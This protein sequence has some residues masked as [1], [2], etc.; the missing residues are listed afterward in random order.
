MTM[1]NRNHQRYIMPDVS[2]KSASVP[3]RN[4][5]FNK[6]LLNSSLAIIMIIR[7]KLSSQW[8]AQTIDFGKA[9]LELRAPFVSAINDGWAVGSRE[10]ATD[11]ANLYFPSLLN[12]RD[13]VRID[14]KVS[15]CRC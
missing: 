13:S 10:R 1:K 3:E 9:F 15:K 11:A 4:P 5:K 7:V 8:L 14:G 2:A 6:E 12:S